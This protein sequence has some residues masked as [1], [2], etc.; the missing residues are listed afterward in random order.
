[1]NYGDPLKGRQRTK[2]VKEEVIKPPKKVLSGAVVKALLDYDG[3]VGDG[4]IRWAERWLVQLVRERSLPPQI[5]GSDVMGALSQ[6]LPPS[7]A[8]DVLKR[9]RED[10]RREHPAMF[11]KEDFSFLVKAFEAERIPLSSPIHSHL[12][13]LIS[14]S[15]SQTDA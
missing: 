8:L 2:E 6:F 13:A 15:P 7:D 1:M 11:P 12:L 14:P 10:F 5:A 9:V 4:I 3:V